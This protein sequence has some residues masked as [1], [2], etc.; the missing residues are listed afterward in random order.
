MQKALRLLFPLCALILGWFG[1]GLLSKEPE[2][3]K[4]P[5]PSPRVIKTKVIELVRQDFVLDPVK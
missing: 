1:Y 3:A 2:K 4:R 5:V